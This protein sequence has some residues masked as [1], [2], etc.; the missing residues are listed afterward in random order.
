MIL[1]VTLEVVRQL[2]DPAGEEGNLHVRTAGIFFVELELLHVHRVTAFCHNEGRTLGEESRLARKLSPLRGNSTT[3]RAGA[4]STPQ[5]SDKPDTARGWRE[6]R[7]RIRLATRSHSLSGKARRSHG[8]TAGHT[9]PR[10]HSRSGCR[11][12]GPQSRE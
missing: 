10:R 12:E 5:T 7:S 11:R 8:P 4:A 1:R 6:T 9:R 2:R 3:H